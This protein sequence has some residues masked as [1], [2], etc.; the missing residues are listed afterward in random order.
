MASSANSSNVSNFDSRARTG[1]NRHNASE[2]WQRRIGSVVEK[3][4]A[5]FNS[6]AVNG[7]GGVHYSANTFG[8]KWTWERDTYQ[9]IDLSSGRVLR[10]WD[11]GTVINL[12]YGSNGHLRLGGQ[13]FFTN[14]GGSFQQ[15][16][17]INLICNA[18]RNDNL[19]PISN[20]LLHTLPKIIRRP[21]NVPL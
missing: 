15:R 3:P 13:N 10:E 18:H 8:N 16:T 4:F 20:Y 14:Q 7:L 1:D 17:L 19:S 6:A 2:N 12:R 5:N 9:L 21:K 11:G